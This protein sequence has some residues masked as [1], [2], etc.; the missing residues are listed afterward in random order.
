VNTFLGENFGGLR[1][2]VMF[3]LGEVWKGGREA[4]SQQ[5]T[6]RTDI[7]LEI[8]PTKDEEKRRA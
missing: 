5:I 3:V 2:I 4:P 8:K 7:M 6:F 1:N